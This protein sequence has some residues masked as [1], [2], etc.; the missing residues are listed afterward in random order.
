MRGRG[1]GRQR[2]GLA[3][4]CRWGERIAHVYWCL[5][6]PRNPTLNQ[7]PT[8]SI[9]VRPTNKIK[10]LRHPCRGL[11]PYKIWFRSV[12]PRWAAAFSC[13]VTA[14]FEFFDHT[15]IRAVFPYSLFGLHTYCVSNCCWQPMN[16][17]RICPISWMAWACSSAVIVCHRSKRRSCSSYVVNIEKA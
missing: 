4:L 8:S 14:S 17:W 6:N 16:W 15:G 12:F 2:R 11:V 13:I 9:P 10:D 7:R 1:R 5:S 3:S